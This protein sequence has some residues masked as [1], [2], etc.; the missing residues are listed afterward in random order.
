MSYNVKNIKISK[1]F[2]RRKTGKARDEEKKFQDRVHF[3]NAKDAKD[4]D[5]EFVG[6]GDAASFR[7]YADDYY[8]PRRAGP[9][10]ANSFHNKAGQAAALHVDD[11]GNNFTV[12]HYQSIHADEYRASTVRIP[13]G[14]ISGFAMIQKPVGE[15]ERKALALTDHHTRSRVERA[16]LNRQ[17]PG[18]RDAG[19]DDRP[20][21]PGQEQ[22]QARSNLEGISRMGVS[23]SAY[24]SVNTAGGQEDHF[25]LI[26]TQ[27]DYMDKHMESS[28]R[29][30]G[31]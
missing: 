8:A 29:K 20:D 9:K 5:F 15:S 30:V 17:H 6:E 16:N 14:S 27:D 11:S 25:E 22:K 28:K 18:A 13:D 21:R 19:R 4:D 2:K 26:G 3:V 1:L 23:R 12:N 24:R 10:A 31:K 7:E